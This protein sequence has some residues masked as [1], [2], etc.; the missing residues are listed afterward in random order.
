MPTNGNPKKQS[1]MS[2]SR[3][4]KALRAAGHH[5]A[6]VVQVGKEGVTPA[7]LQQLDEAVLAHELVKVKVGS[8]C[9]EDR[10]EVAARFAAVPGMLLAQLLGRTLL[11]YRRHPSGRGSSR[12]PG[13]APAEHEAPGAP[14]ASVNDVAVAGDGAAGDQPPAHVL[15]VVG[16]GDPLLQQQPLGHTGLRQRQRQVLTGLLEPRLDPV[17]AL[18]EVV[19][20]GPQVG[21]AA[22][23]P[24]RLDRQQR[25]RAGRRGSDQQVLH[26][27]R[28]LAIPFRGYKARGAESARRP[29]APGP[30]A[31]ML[32]PWRL[33]S[34]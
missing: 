27:G 8:E 10:F 13:A 32:G 30:R 4:R 28:M 22:P 3:L 19:D 23:R 25:Q 6:P 20:A 1:L 17:E 21:L 16:V 31:A 12:V 2:A 33:D 29:L 18:A 11:V 7:V 34:T 5:L 9:P 14:R 15:H 26:G 24:P